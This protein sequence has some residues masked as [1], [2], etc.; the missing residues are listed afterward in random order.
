MS[1][2]AGD[3]KMTGRM[4]EPILSDRWSGKN[5]T[6]LGLGR[7]G[8]SAAEYLLKHGAQVTLSE[9]SNVEGDRLQEVE[10]LRKL[11]AT[12]ETGAHS[13]Y[14]ISSADLIVVSPG[15]P[16]S[17]EVIRRAQ[18]EGKEVIC[19]IE[20]AYRDSVG[21]VPI[22]G[23]TGTNGKS[24]TCAMISHILEKSGLK[25]PACGNFG[26]PILDQLEKKPDYLVAEVSSY[27]LHYCPTFA[28]K[29]GVWLNLTPDH[30]E[31][32]GGLNGYIEAKQRMFLN[33]SEDKYAVLNDDDPIVANFEPPSEI[34]PF[35]VQSEEESAIQ[36]AYMRGEYLCY[37]MDG[38]SN[39][40]CSI[41]DLK[42]I[43]KH[44]LENALAAI[45][46]AA[47]LRLRHED[48]V[49]GVTSFRALEHR[50]EF[51]DTVGGVDFY[52]D[53][54][55]TNPTSTVK[56]LEAFGQKKVVLIA[57]GRDKGT[58]LDELV[59]A[60]RK[61]VSEVILIGE[62][63]E[64]FA[65]ALEQASYRHVKSVKS[66]EEAIDLGASMNK[67]PV[68]LSPACASFD[69]FKDYEE[70]GRVFKNL[71]RARLEK[72]AASH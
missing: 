28:P 2:G 67:G 3:V 53:S 37:R 45:A 62:A 7:S 5:V 33:Q 18:D 19:D 64:R 11:G 29:I 72:I 17:S 69:M 47:L 68:V 9:R 44:N 1:R 59:R 58:S 65:Q 21:R 66:M 46:V 50:L 61:H 38:E 56:A 13:E 15:I 52:N 71:V 4:R 36:A 40:V 10:N 16:P 49:L 34:F 55:A 35:S 57:G 12:V 27:Q 48:I 24:T 22:I 20:L 23:I 42:I 6:V 54:K 39:L 70:R 8:T 43:G 31:W 25:A 63:S 14:A 32:H 51:V 41:D 26:V 30:I 60:I